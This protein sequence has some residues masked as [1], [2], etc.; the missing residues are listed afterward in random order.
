MISWSSVIAQF[1]AVLYVLLSLVLIGVLIV[2]ILRLRQ[3]FGESF[4][5]QVF[6]L[7]SILV[8]FVICYLSRSIFDTLFYSDVNMH[9]DEF[10]NKILDLLLPLLW[11]ALPICLI[12]LQ[13]R[14]SFSKSSLQPINDYLKS[15]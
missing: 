2:I 10:W 4:K 14:S 11:E 13:H 8:S 3:Y 7:T 9:L 6:K 15:P 1:L 5:S 12:F